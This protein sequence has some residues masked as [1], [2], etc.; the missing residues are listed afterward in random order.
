[1]TNIVTLLTTGELLKVHNAVAK[2]PVVKFRDRRT[3]E[4]KVDSLTMGMG[5]KLVVLL[6]KIGVKDDVVQVLVAKLNPPPAPVK[7]AKVPGEFEAHPMLASIREL[8]KKAKKDCTTSTADVAELLGV[9]TAKVVAQCDK[10]SEQKLIDIED[11]SVSTEDKFYYLHLTELGL[12]CKVAD[13]DPSAGLGRI[14]REPKAPRTN[15]DGTAWVK[16]TVGERM[17]FTGKSINRL[18]EVNP[19]MKGSARWDAFELA[20]SKMTFEDFISKGGAK[21]H[22]IEMVQSGLIEMV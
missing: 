9:P 16:R 10:F 15:P 7:A 1:V 4:A 22:I 5:D 8:V 20:K 2:T 21:K 18:T 13:G 3:A 11:D 6:K 19:R 12:S 14:K 17:N